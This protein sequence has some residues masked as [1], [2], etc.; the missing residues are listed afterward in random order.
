M[1]RECYKILEVFERHVFC[2]LHGYK[3]VIMLASSV[4]SKMESRSLEE[5]KK[6]D[7]PL[8]RFERRTFSSL[9]CSTSETLCL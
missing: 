7:L 8:R 9:V 6:N 3:N 5:E 2:L 4:V 1:N